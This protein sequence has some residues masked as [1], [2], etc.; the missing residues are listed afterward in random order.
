MIAGADLPEELSALRSG[1]EQLGWTDRLV[2]DNDTRAL[3]RAGT[4]RSWGV[5]VVC[6]SG[7]NCIGVAPDGRHVRFPS[8]GDITG[9]WGGGTD[10]GMAALAAAARSADGRGPETVLER[11]VPEFFEFSEPLD[12]ARAI[13][14]REM[15]TER[16]GELAR[17]VFSAAQNGDLV[18]AQIVGR[19]AEEIVTFAAATLKRLELTDQAPDVVLGGGLIRAASETML[20][21]IDLGVRRVAPDATLIVSRTGPIVGA[22]LLGLDELGADAA[23]GARI[24]TELDEAFASVERAGGQGPDGRTVTIGPTAAGVWAG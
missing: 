15:P 12:V 2:V 3:L 1:F 7:I 23:A 20:R 18:S 9:D 24:R 13:H 21:E 19:V 6:G 10:V 22:A 8:L 11:A 4:D 16:L 17:V 5:A 14:L